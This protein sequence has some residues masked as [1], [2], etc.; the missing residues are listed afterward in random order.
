MKCVVP[1]PAPTRPLLV[2][3]GSLGLWELDPDGPQ[4][5]YRLGYTSPASWELSA[6]RRPVPYRAREGLPARSNGEDRTDEGLMEPTS[7][8]SLRGSPGGRLLQSI[9]PSQV[10]WSWH[11]GDWSQLGW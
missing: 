4:A 5:A 3:R 11:T 2:A 7:G 1:Q 10:S 8:G 6:G 9:E